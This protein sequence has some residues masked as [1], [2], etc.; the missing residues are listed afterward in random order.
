MGVAAP[1]TI[2]SNFDRWPAKKEISDT[3]CNVHLFGIVTARCR[4]SATPCFCIFGT[5]GYVAG[6]RKS[7]HSEVSMGG[8]KNKLSKLSNKVKNLLTSNQFLPLD[9]SSASGTA[10][11][12]TSGQP[13]VRRSEGG[14]RSLPD[15]VINNK[16]PLWLKG[17]VRRQS[18][19][20]IV[21]TKYLGTACLS[22]AILS[23]LVF[24]I[25]SSY[26]YSKVNS[27]AEPVNNSSTSALDSIDPTG[28]S[29]SIS[30]Y[31][32]S[33]STG[34]NDPN[35]SLSIPQGG[36]MATG[37]HTVEVNVGS[38]IASYE[39]RLS[40][41][42][43]ETALVNEGISNL[44]N[45]RIEPIAGKYNASG[46]TG[47]R[48][49][50]ASESNNAWAY[51]VDA[52]SIAGA[53]ETGYVAPLP[54]TN[55]PDIILSNNGNNATTTNIYYGAKVEH[56]EQLLA[57]DYT[58]GVVYTVVAELMPE[59]R[60]GSVSPDQYAVNDK[61]VGIWANDN[62]GLSYGFT[63]LKKSGAIFSYTYDSIFNDEFFEAP[64]Q[65]DKSVKYFTDYSTSLQE[66]SLAV[67]TD[68]QIITWNFS[69]SRNYGTLGNGTTNELRL[70]NYANITDSI[71][72][73][74]KDAYTKLNRVAVTTNTGKAYVWGAG[75]GNGTG[76]TEVQL[77]P[78]D[79]SQRFSLSD[80][81]SIKS[82][83]FAY[84]R[85]MALSEF[86]RVFE[87]QADGSIDEISDAFELNSE[88][89]VT[90]ISFAN[91]RVSGQVYAL[92]LT[93]D[94]RVISWGC[95]SYG[96]LGDG[97]TSSSDMPVDITG[98]FNLSNGDY[99]SVIHTE[100]NTSASYAV[101][102]YGRVFAWGNYNGDDV[103]HSTPADI[104]DLF[105]GYSIIQLSGGWRYLA[106]L[107][108]DGHVYL[109]M[110]SK[111]DITSK[112]DLPSL[113][114]LTGSNFTNVNNVYIDLNADGTMQSNEQCTDLTVNSDT[115]LTCNVPMDDSIA[116]GDYTMYIETPYNY[117][118]TTF[119]YENY[120]E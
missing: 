57:G 106:G 31:S 93:T 103:I 38:S 40:S 43:E 108:D 1:S 44:S 112:F 62:G 80:G 26:S 85:G 74:P 76:N 90:S 5:I 77:S 49:I 86:G 34:S 75:G 119:R 37:R 56:P 88:E 114:T 10:S 82:I 73:E 64:M 12:S 22:L 72:G 95:N 2:E 51:S 42:T 32:S 115:E 87:L 41:K 28:I 116:T 96:E 16:V 66:N 83:R 109:P 52:R 48:N 17:N 30:S 65:L 18:D 120:G 3:C 89:R 68:N 78:V 99:I 117:T 58:A 100:E 59:P 97:S 70:P 55:T 54:S 91:G 118:T 92:A 15:E 14:R 9:R 11:R 4:E 69:G 8:I 53:I 27:N 94:N 39:L 61:I 50:L 47:L 24:N 101:S 105:N 29:I 110:L 33:S 60:I 102:R 113:I 67:T 6:L 81:D 7:N 104:T 46:E 79:I 36:G 20:G 111:G 71:D 45:T 35:L 84:N 21:L 23:T 19:K 63:A 98:N 13:E 107:S 25:I